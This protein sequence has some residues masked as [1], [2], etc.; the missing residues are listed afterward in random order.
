MHTANNRK[1]QSGG[2]R[3]FARVTLSKLAAGISAAMSI[4]V[5][6]LGWNVAAAQQQAQGALEEIVVSARRRDESL[7]D[8]PMSIEAFNTADIELRGIAQGSDLGLL[9]PNMTV[10]RSDPE[11]DSDSIVI[12]GVNGVGIYLDG[13]WSTNRAFL[14]GSLVDLERVEVLRGPQGTLF[15]RNTNGGAIQYVTARPH[16]EF[17]GRANFTIGERNQLDAGLSMNIPLA[18]NLAMRIT[19][20]TMTRDGYIESL[21]LNEKSLFGGAYGGQDDRYG[22]ADLFWTPKDTV[23]VRYTLDVQEQ[24]TGNPRQVRW[25]RWGNNDFIPYAEHWRQTLINVVALN[26]DYGPYDFWPGSPPNF[27]LGLDAFTAE[28]H[29]AGY[30]GGVV[31]QW[32]NRGNTPLDGFQSEREQHTFTVEWDIG[33]RL[34]LRSITA[35]REQTVGDYTDYDTSEFTFLQ[36]MR[37][38][39]DSIA[40]QE[41]HLTGSAKDGRISFLSGLY[42]SDEENVSRSDPGFWYMD[43]LFVYNDAGQAVVDPEA[44]AFVRAW[45]AANLNSTD[46]FKSTLWVGPLVN[47]VPSAGLRKRPGGP[48]YSEAKDQAFFGEV[49][50]DFTPKLQTTFGVRWT[51]DESSSRS[52]MPTDAFVSLLR[53]NSVS[54][55][56][57]SGDVFAG[58]T[59]TESENDTPGSVFTPKVSLS[60]RFND[61]LMAYASYSEGFT[62]GE[63]NYQTTLERY[64][65][66]DPEVVK[67][68]EIGVRSD[69]LDGRLRLNATAFYSYWQGIRLTNQIQLPNGSFTNTQVS[70]GTAESQGVEMDLLYRPGGNWQLNFGLA[71]LDTNYLEVGQNDPLLES[72]LIPGAPWAYAPE[73]SGSFGGQY[74]WDL[75]SGAGLLFRADFGFQSRYERNADVQRRRPDL[76]G[77]PGYGELSARLRYTPQAE[78]WALT[79]FGSNLLDKYAVIGGIDAGQLWGLDF[80]QPNYPRQVGATFSFFF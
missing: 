49:S 29:E 77:E 21:A 18:Q 11:N 20:S 42:V 9:V 34:S 51:W 73:W 14:L 7:Q 79:V 46:P 26:P 17:E 30:P 23:S 72:P 8:V 25:S 52:T 15:G 62:R 63:V 45:G 12:R 37:Y 24:V 10:G 56:Y 33:D 36:T 50:V 80:V 39:R 65:T 58:S 13:V 68:R 61:N 57:S 48:S 28:T 5:P 71:Y 66:L 59:L 55:A 4:A 54:E 53:P 67:T 27:N 3:S 31:G 35:W 16:N 43:D 19:G 6:M 78:Q 32:E 47:W 69:M 75:A 2:T 40:S 22:R 76:G 70:A 38:Y 44:L 60:Y 74:E 41:I 64:I 1:A